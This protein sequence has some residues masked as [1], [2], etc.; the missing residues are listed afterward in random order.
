[1][2]RLLKKLPSPVQYILL[3]YGTGMLIFSFFRLLLLWLHRDELKEIP[4]SVIF[5]SLLMGLRFDAVIS[6]Y[7][8]VLPAV[9]FFLLSFF[10]KDKSVLNVISVFIV[11]VYTVSFFMHIS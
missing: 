2:N 1:M 11:V 3:V 10:K 6:G 9:V 7:L 4:S 8:L 5:Q